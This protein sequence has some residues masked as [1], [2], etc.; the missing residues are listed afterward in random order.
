[1]LRTMEVPNRGPIPTVIYTQSSEDR[2]Y[3]MDSDEDPTPPPVP[4]SMYWCFDDRPLRGSSVSLNELG[5]PLADKPAVT[6]EVLTHWGNTNHLDLSL[7][8]PPLQAALPRT[9]ARSASVVE[10]LLRGQETIPAPLARNV[11]RSSALQFSDVSEI[12]SHE[13]HQMP[14]S[15]KILKPNIQGFVTRKPVPLAR[16]PLGNLYDSR[17]GRKESSCTGLLLASA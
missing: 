12:P 3:C 13:K 9:A 17:L 6:G 8:E 15:T 2:E 4:S 5:I 10:E 11:L 1:M 7:E 16:S 14:G